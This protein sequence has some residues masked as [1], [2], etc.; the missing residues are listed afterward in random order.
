MK[1]V[2]PFTVTAFRA[3]CDFK[4]CSLKLAVILKIVPK[5]GHECTLKKIDSLQLRKAR[6]KI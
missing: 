5:A 3:A 2:R 4:S 6:T 1:L